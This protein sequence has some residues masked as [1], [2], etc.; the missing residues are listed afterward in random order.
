MSKSII[1]VVM[2]ILICGVSVRATEILV[3]FGTRTPDRWNAVLIDGSYN[4]IDSENHSTGYTLQFTDAAW[5]NYYEYI[6]PPCH[7][8]A[9][10]VD[11]AVAETYIE[12]QGGNNRFEFEIIGLDNSLDYQIDLF[13]EK[14]A[15]VSY[16]AAD[17]K[18]NG[19]FTLNSD[20][21]NYVKNSSEIMTWNVK[22]IN[23]KIIV[24]V[25][26]VNEAP[27]N[28][29][30]ISYIPEPATLLLLGLGGLVLRGKN[31]AN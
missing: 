23:N 17:Y 1:L 22:P 14:G 2:V 27:L 18:V 21:F 12:G 6:A 25:E 16:L 24:S 13:A 19:E 7:G 9:A 11:E 31:Y 20:N 29:M 26:V 4:L 8:D 30:R 3:N 28:A 5:T 15:S 10:W